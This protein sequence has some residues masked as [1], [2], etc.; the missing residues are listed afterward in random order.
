MS[1]EIIIRR[2]G[3]AGRITLNR[4]AA[5]NTLT[6]AMVR[7]MVDC[8]RTWRDDPAIHLVIIDGAGE[9]AFCAGGDIRSFYDAGPEDTA[10][11]KRFWREEYALN[12]M[13]AHYPKPYVAVMD[14]ITMGGGVG[15]SAHGSYRI[16][17]ER[18]RLAMPETAI[19]L[20]PDVGG[21][22]LL[23][24]APDDLGVYFGLTGTAMG[25]SDA[26]YMGFADQ[27]VK[28]ESIGPLIAELSHAPLSQ[29][30]EAISRW[31]SDPGAPPIRTYESEIAKAFGHDQVEQS[32]Q[33]LHDMDS[34]WSQSILLDLGSRS[35]LSLKLTMAAIHHAR[36]V[37]SLEEALNVEYRLTSRLLDHGEFL[38]GVR[39]LIVHKDRQ[40][41]WNPNNLEDVTDEMVTHFLAPLPTAEALSLEPPTMAANL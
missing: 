21:T 7:A 13:I 8:F 38:E 33:V 20:I 29:I 18:T 6:L 4:P 39:A 12:A 16:V 1:E 23:A 37:Q 10:F 35:P 5:L 41:N 26:I 11:G 9:K 32:M 31:S 3:T 40:P 2:Q 17:T 28:T 27:F 30:G 34:E 25:A 36:K 24:R 22:Y 15:V 14:G 19:G